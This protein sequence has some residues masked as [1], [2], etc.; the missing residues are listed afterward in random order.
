VRLFAIACVRPAAVVTIKFRAALGAIGVPGEQCF[1]HDAQPSG[2]RR[3]NRAGLTRRTLGPDW[4]RRPLRSRWSRRARR[5]YGSG[6]TG[7]AGRPH[8]TGGTHRTDGTTRAYRPAGAEQSAQIR[9]GRREIA[10]RAAEAHAE[11]GADNDRAERDGE[12]S[13]GQPQTSMVSFDF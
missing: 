1:G 10:D 9:V 4:T 5:A 2:P 7:W 13:E 11:E 3:T 6:R 12:G 8:R